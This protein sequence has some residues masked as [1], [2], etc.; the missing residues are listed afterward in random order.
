MSYTWKKLADSYSSLTDA[1]KQ[2][3]FDSTNYLHATQAQLQ[4]LGKVKILVNDDYGTKHKIKMTAVPNDQTVV[5]KKLISTKSIENID[6]ITILSTVGNNTVL[7]IAVTKDLSKY[8]SFNGTDWVEVS[9]IKNDGNTPTEINS[10]SSEN[11]DKFINGANGIAFEYFLSITDETDK[12]NTDKLSMQ[13]D[14]K[15][16]WQSALKGTD[17]N[18]GYSANDQLKVTLLTDGSYKINYTQ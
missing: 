6:S 11:W 9:D 16:T 18:Y 10:I 17:F 5:P 2:K 15:G 13:V 12:L 8:Y 14:M 1:Q 7:K 4:S 3:L